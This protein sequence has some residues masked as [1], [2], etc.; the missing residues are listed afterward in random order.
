M[1]VELDWQPDM[2]NST[3]DIDG[4]T[5]RELAS[6]ADGSLE[7]D[8]VSRLLTR[9]DREP[10]LADELAVQLRAL[11]SILTVSHPTAPVALRKR[12]ALLIS[13]AAR[14]RRIPGRL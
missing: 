11:V 13:R 8:R 7:S 4:R 3:R 5:M 2:S 9:L 12:V 1:E 14:A 10:R 6:L